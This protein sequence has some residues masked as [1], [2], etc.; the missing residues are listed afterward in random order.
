MSLLF[1]TLVACSDYGFFG[2]DAE[3]PDGGSLELVTPGVVVAG[4]T[5]AAVDSATPCGDAD[6]DGFDDEACGGDDCDDTDAA[7]HPGAD[8]ICDLLDNDCDG[9][10]GDDEIDDDGDGSA[11]CAGDCDDEEPWLNT[12]DADGDGVS[13][14]DGDC[15]D[16][17]ARITPLDPS[18]AVVHVEAGGSGDGSLDDPLGTI[19]DAVASDT[20]VCVWPGSYDPVSLTSLSGVELLGPGDETAV[21]E[22]ALSLQ[23]TS[24]S[25]LAGLTANSVNSTNSYSDASSRNVFEHLVLDCDGDLLPGG[26]YGVVFFGLGDHDNLLRDSELIGCTYGAYLN[27]NQANESHRIEGNT[28]RDQSFAAVHF[29]WNLGSLVMNNLVTGLAA[30]HSEASAIDVDASVRDDLVLSNTV[31]DPDGAPGVDVDGTSGSGLTVWANLVLGSSDAGVV[32]SN[33]HA[34]AYDNL[35]ENGAASTL[36]SGSL[37]Q[38]ESVYDDLVAEGD[39]YVASRNLTATVPA[40]WSTE[41]DVDRDGDDDR[42]ETLCVVGAWGDGNPLFAPHVSVDAGVVSWTLC[43]GDA[44]ETHRQASFQVQ[45]AEAAWPR[46]PEAV[47]DSGEVTGTD[48]SHTLPDASE[49]YVRVRVRDEAGAW[50]AWSDGLDAG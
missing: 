11:T 20:I 37:A 17:D 7:V 13:T 26:A 47:Y 43:D 32:A 3:A 10:L 28:F 42:G 36:S 6:G 21:V 35:L 49:V 9:E 24:D 38:L 23:N 4:D 19:Q 48:T 12:L 2:R 46:E 31:V 27:G 41:I 39:G 30:G 18:R 8:E 16:D 45:A 40:G 14:C 25:H 34:V 22:G 50:S 44:D 1:A 15:F 33:S 29:N 5:D